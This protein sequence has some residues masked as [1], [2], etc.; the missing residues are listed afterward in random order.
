[1]ANGVPGIIPAITKSISAS[2][3]LGDTITITK[4]TIAKTARSRFT[5]KPPYVIICNCS[6]HTTQLTCFQVEFMD[7]SILPVTYDTMAA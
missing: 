6:N 2:C 3:T 1:M 7:V 4:L 5:K